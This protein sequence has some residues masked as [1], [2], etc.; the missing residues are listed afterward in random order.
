MIASRVK[1]VRHGPGR[2]VV[3]GRDTTITRKTKLSV[4]PSRRQERELVAC[5]DAT[6]EVYNGGLQHRRD[7][8]RTSGHAVT[9]Y[10]Q[11]SGPDSLTTIRQVRPD[12]YQW[13]LQPLRGALRRLDEAYAAFFR[14]CA[15][16]QT[17]GHP[18]FKGRSRWNTIMWDEPTGWKVDVDRRVV[19]VGGVGDIR[20][21]KG[22]IRQQCRMLARR[23]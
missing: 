5:L 8:W 20:L 9:L 16:G 18:R 3:D 23:R 11:F 15:A 17:P 7:A 19:H 1:A 13:G 6:R 2:L 10:D 4:S 21:P 12:L 14:R 22:S